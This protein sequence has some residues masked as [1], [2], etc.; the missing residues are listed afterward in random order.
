MAGTNGQAPPTSQAEALQPSKKP[1]IPNST[2][3]LLGGTVFFALS[4]LITRRA[5]LRKRI[6][7]LPPTYT[8]APFH[9]PSANGGLEA[10]E[11]LNIATINVASVA[12]IGVGAGMYAF[13]IDTLE[14]LKRKVRS[15]MEL[16]G[17]GE[18][19]QQVE[20]ELEKWVANVMS[21]KAGKEKKESEVE[22]K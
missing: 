6:S 10:L 7:T 20:E 12:M 14:D 18:S 17:S 21:W 15:G 22:R 19:E 9:R 16:D 1:L 5:F 8:S 4:S 2:K 13:D 11:A 3:L